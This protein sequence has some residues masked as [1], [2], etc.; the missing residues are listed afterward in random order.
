LKD[1]LRGKFQDIVLNGKLIFHELGLFFA[2]YKLHAMLLSY[3]EVKEITLVVGD[4]VNWMVIK[5]KDSRGIPG[6][7]LVG[8]EPTI[9]LRLPE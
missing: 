9:Y 3:E 2:D 6:N 7:L 4:K 1:E 5:P 8:E